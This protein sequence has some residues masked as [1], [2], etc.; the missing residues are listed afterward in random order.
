MD[1]HA[2]LSELAGEV[3]YPLVAE[4]LEELMVEEDH[5]MCVLRLSTYRKDESRDMDQYQDIGNRQ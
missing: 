2:L 4:V 3:G 5:Y 1:A